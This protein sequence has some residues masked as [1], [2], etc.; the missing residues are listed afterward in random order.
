MQ[1]LKDFNEVLDHIE[2]GWR[3]MV[4]L[5]QLRR[6]YGPDFTTNTVKRYIANNRPKLEV[7]KHG[8][9]GW[10]VGRKTGE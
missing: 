9:Y 10:C 5:P 4:S 1:W 8:R 2:S 6:Q 3:G 7:Y